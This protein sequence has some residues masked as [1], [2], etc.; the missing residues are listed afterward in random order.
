MADVLFLISPHPATLCD[1]DSESPRL[2]RRRLL[3]AA[4]VVSG[5]A[6]LSAVEASIAEA[7]QPD[8]ARAHPA[9][10]ADT[11]ALTR[12]S[13]VVRTPEEF[14]AAGDGVTDDTDALQ[15]AVDAVREAGTGTVALAPG[16]TYLVSSVDIQHGLT[17][18]GRG[19]RIIR[20][21]HHPSGLRTLTTQHRP[22]RTAAEHA[23]PI[24]LRNL[25]VDGSIHEQGPFRDYEQEQSSL[26]F[27]NGRGD[28]PHRQ[29]IRIEDVT[30]KNSVSD[31]IHLWTNTDATITSLEG[32]DC[33]RGG[34]TITG[35]DS[36]V[37]LDG[38]RGS[39]DVTGAHIDIEL[40]TPS[41][42]R[43]H[44]DFEL[45]DAI[46]EDG[47]HTRPTDIECGD[48]GRA[49]IENCAFRSGFTMMGLGG[50]IEVRDSELHGKDNSE[51]VVP[52]TIHRGDDVT[53]TRCEFLAHGTRVGTPRSETLAAVRIQHTYSFDSEAMSAPRHVVFDRCTF[54]PA[55][56]EGT[57]DGDEPVV[58][59]WVAGTSA[60][61]GPVVVHD[62]SFD[63]GLAYGVDMTLGGHLVLEGETYVDS[64]IGLR[65]GSLPPGD[66]QH[67]IEVEG[68][69]V[70]PRNDELWQLDG[71]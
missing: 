34:L 27:L 48:D 16:A 44:G 42:G 45:R 25:T 26:I 67:V 41:N 6:A 70:G 35:G 56:A 50:T 7:P 43:Y 10:L 30:V 59:I 47:P 13:G 28:T 33:F 37:R 17:I 55:P 64:Q 12:A 65:V 21:P 19:A 53:F 36:R 22:A 39:G 31:G 1:M 9:R 52:R 58:G 15:A 3:G 8:A 40:D 46:I 49:L 57:N 54:S 29:V 11:D 51:G 4:A 23:R 63:A 24:V 18:D 32:V 5:V 62:C 66:D 60:S 69:E 61:S 20:P 38:Y 68:L 14:G 71:S 2:P